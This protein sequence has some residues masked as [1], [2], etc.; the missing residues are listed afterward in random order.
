MAQSRDAQKQIDAAN[1]DRDNAVDALN[2]A[3]RQLNDVNNRLLELA[4]S[5]PSQAHPVTGEADGV[6]AALFRSHLPSVYTMSLGA[7][8]AGALK[9]TDL[10]RLLALVGPG[11][12]WLLMYESANPQCVSCCLV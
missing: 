9:R 6:A 4:G 5:G 8:T 3:Q 10:R 2:T 11:C 1:R 12:S 7:D